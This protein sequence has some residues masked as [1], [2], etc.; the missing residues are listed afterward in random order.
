[1]QGQNRNITEGRLIASREVGKKDFVK[2]G[3]K[4]A[5][6]NIGRTLFNGHVLLEFFLENGESV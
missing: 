4:L 2:T 5:L 1:M 3:L 6:V